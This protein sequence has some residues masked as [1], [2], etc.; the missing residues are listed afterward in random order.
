MNEI[1]NKTTPLLV[2]KLKN[3]FNDREFIIGILTYAD[4]EE[5]QKTI[6]NFI[7]EDDDVTVETVTVLALN[8]CDMRNAT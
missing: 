1:Y 6:I 4:N 2:E 7:N 8:L 3:I 5:D